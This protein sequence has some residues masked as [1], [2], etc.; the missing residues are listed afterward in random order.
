MGLFADWQ[1]SEAETINTIFSN[2]KLEEPRAHLTIVGGGL[3]GILLALKL[4]RE[5]S[6][7]PGTILLV[8]A[9]TNLGGR[10]L[11]SD[12]RVERMAA[13]DDGE[14]F[15]Q[16]R[17][18]GMQNGVSGPGFE[19]VDPK[20]LEILERHLRSALT[21]EELQ[22]LDLICG[23]SEGEAGE[24][25]KTYFVRREPVPWRAALSGSSDAFTRKEAE[26]LS[27]LVR[28]AETE[29]DN[30]AE[31]AERIRFLESPVWKEASAATKEGV[32]PTLEA[33]LGRAC[34]EA[35]QRD[36]FSG[37]R[38]FS[39]LASE[40][41]PSL[42]RRNSGIEFA[43]ELLLR[44]RGV[45]VLTGTRVT[46][47]VQGKN[48][49]FELALSGRGGRLYPKIVSSRVVLAVPLISCFS[50]LPR[51][52]FT[53]TQS[54]SV[55]RSP[56]FS[57][58]TVEYPKAMAHAQVGL[59]TALLPGSRFIFPTERAMGLVNSAGNLL[60]YGFLGYE[61]S[62]E[63]ASVRESVSRLRRAAARLLKEEALKGLSGQDALASKNAVA[64]RVILL[65]A[66]RYLQ[67]PVAS[68]KDT[69]M[70]AKGLY[71]CGD[72]FTYSHNSWKNIV[73]SVQDVASHL[74][75]G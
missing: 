60:C 18:S 3:S 57:L 10:L 1:A 7:I 50:F 20:G 59:E 30:E 2:Q 63:A 67:I 65:S 75:K 33:L 14:F 53:G 15:K 72:G 70:G 68:M 56:P 16:R 47:L 26:F 64:E 45:R 48:G 62:L 35:P 38:A 46:R 11:F 4:S 61:D 51:D 54:K 74:M 55:L 27:E 8:D 36:L 31:G 73:D 40:E 6:R 23:E 32:T 9:G 24:P 13:E 42:F 69:R 52:L 34:L 58:V 43:L 37:L 5:Q 41:P 71:Y 29:P 12:A 66:A 28:C 22:F 49:E 39:H 21:D 17:D 19:S 25:S 44:S